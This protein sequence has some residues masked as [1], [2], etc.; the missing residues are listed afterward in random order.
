MHHSC[1][2]LRHPP[3]A[4]GHAQPDERTHH[5]AD[6]AKAPLRRRAS[7]GTIKRMMVGGRFLTR[8]FKGTRTEI[9]LSVLAYN[10]LRAINIKATTV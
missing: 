6:D 7:F 9:A 4:R 5:T 8:S 3:P 1:A 10:M 2:P